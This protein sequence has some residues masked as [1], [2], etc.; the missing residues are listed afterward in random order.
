M[1]IQPEKQ[2]IDRLFSNESY[3]I[4]FYQRE[5]KWETQQVQ[6]LLNDLFHNFEPEFKGHY[7]VEPT[8]SNILEKYSWYYLNT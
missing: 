4:D 5:Y 2:N 8:K 6:T 1:E 7:S 3:K